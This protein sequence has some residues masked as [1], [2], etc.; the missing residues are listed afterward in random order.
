[1]PDMYDLRLWLPK[2]APRQREN[3]LPSITDQ[4]QANG[5]RD[6]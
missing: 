4:L 6:S 3:H 5:D 1:M 2:V